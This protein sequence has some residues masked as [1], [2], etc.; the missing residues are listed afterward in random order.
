MAAL[1]AQ[2][3]G[4]LYTTIIYVDETFVDFVR[5]FILKVE[6][7]SADGI[8]FSASRGKENTVLDATPR[9]FKTDRFSD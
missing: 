2:P 3:V 6:V 5:V 8:S 7:F 1:C 9:N 4:R